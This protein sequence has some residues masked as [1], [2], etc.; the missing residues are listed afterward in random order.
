[1]TGEKFIDLAATLTML[2][3]GG[4]E[5]YR[6]AVSR[7]Y[8]GAFHVVRE[9]FTG[10]LGLTVPPS[11]KKEVHQYI[12]VCLQNSGHAEAASAAS[13]LSALRTDRNTADYDLQ[14]SIFQSQ[15]NARLRV[16]TAHDIVAA[17]RRCD[18]NSATQAAVK[19]GIQAYR[20][21]FPHGR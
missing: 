20:S 4:E 5:H 7:A 2:P 15:K 10:S 9:F 19:A 3:R 11:Q 8:Y 17:I 6:S 13:K 1:M 16:E 21:R 14:D 18:S 12:A